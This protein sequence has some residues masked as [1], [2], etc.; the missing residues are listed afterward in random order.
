MDVARDTSLDPLDS[1]FDTYS[2]IEYEGS[3]LQEFSDVRPLSPITVVSENLDKAP[4]SKSLS[5]NLDKTPQNI[6]I[7][8][9]GAST[10]DNSSTSAQAS[11]LDNYS[12][13][14][15][16][17][18]LADYT[19]QVT[20]IATSKKPRP[21]LLTSYDC[22]R[23]LNEKEAKKKKQVEEKEQRQKDREDKKR[24]RRRS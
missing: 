9:L 14:A 15:L 2:Q 18:L 17:Q 12:N 7:T 11:S 3:I 4:A 1:R 6:S 21:R 13:S 20:P 16:S 23:M 19:P 5:E 8:G 24:Q 10:S 22:L